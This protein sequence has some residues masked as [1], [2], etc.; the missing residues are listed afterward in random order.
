MIVA[1]SPALKVCTAGVRDGI[2]LRE[3]FKANGRAIRPSAPNHLPGASP[4]LFRPLPSWVFRQ[5]DPIFS[6]PGW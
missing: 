1:D 2:L 3:A 4:L 6:S 5:P